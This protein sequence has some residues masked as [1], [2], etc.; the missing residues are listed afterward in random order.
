MQDKVC[1]LVT[2]QIQYL[3]KVQHVV[4]MNSGRIEAQGSYNNV[5]RTHY[6][7]IRNMTS[8]AEI[9]RRDTVNQENQVMFTLRII[10]VCVATDLS[11]L[12]PGDG[13]PK[14]S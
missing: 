11:T 6:D 5:K 3:K 1:V 8:V 10:L 14:C 7:S 2:H 4:L 9:E 13:E 12:L